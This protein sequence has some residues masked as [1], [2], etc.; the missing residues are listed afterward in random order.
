MQYFGRNYP[1]QLASRQAWEAWCTRNVDRPH[2]VRA[3]L[4]WADL[5]ERLIQDHRRLA[6]VAQRTLDIVAERGRLKDSEIDEVIAILRLVWRHG[7]SLR[8][9]AVGIGRLSG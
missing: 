7:D 9:W 5:I 4:L 2:L 6:T 3:A 1:D 8:H